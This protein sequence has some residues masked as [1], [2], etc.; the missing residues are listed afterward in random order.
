M[1]LR[2]KIPVPENADELLALCAPEPNTGCWLWL[3]PHN[4]SGYGNLNHKLVHRFAAELSGRDTTGKVVRHK[5]DTKLCCNPD[6]LAVGSQSDNIRDA[7]AKGRHVSGFSAAYRKPPAARCP[8]G[9]EKAGDNLSVFSSGNGYT[10]R[11]CRACRNA[12][13]RAK[14]G[15]K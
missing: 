6:H 11:V 1:A 14:R 4:G 5:C 13:A 12:K 15:A 10:K 7:V 9:H 8:A 3:G 2:D